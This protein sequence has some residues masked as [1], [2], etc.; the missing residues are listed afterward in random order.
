MS[1]ER[2]NYGIDA[3]GL[4]RNFA[5]AGIASLV[6]GIYFYFA[7]GSDR[8]AL[9]MV[10]VI[11]GIVWGVLG[12]GFAGLMVWS[13]KVGKL[14][15]RDRILDAIPWRGDETVLDAGCG[16]G[17]ML[18][19]A[20][21]RLSTGTAIGVD[22]WRKGDQ[23]GNSPEVTLE[24]ARAEGVDG[25]VEIRDG[26]LRDLPFEDGSFDVVLS[27]LVLHNIHDREE[28]EGALRELMRVLKPGGRLTIV[29]IW[30][31]DG[32]ARVLREGGMKDVRRP[33]LRFNIF[34]PV[35]EVTAKKPD[36]DATTHTV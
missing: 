36:L 10:V 21:K 12:L 24:N 2:A 7:F 25:R 23:S 9:A 34:P 11:V 30:D 19:G 31:T 32:Y 1:D 17:L 13:S 27:S 16:S 26:D 14:R 6:L 4:V 28:R 3:P 29:D 8:P 22:I 20:A 33:G 15:E 5:F 35:R 18:I